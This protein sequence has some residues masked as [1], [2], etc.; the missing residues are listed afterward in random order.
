MAMTSPKGETAMN[1]QYDQEDLIELG[2]ASEETKGGP[3]GVDDYR[4]SLMLG[5]V[6]LTQD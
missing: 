2:T 4:G 5:D 6:G 3:W 1:R